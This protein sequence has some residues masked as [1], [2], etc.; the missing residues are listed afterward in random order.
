MKRKTEIC[1]LE[2]VIN[3]TKK[4]CETQPF[5]K[6]YMFFMN[7]N[8]EKRKEKPEHYHTTVD[9]NNKTS[10]DHHFKGATELGHSHQT[11]SNKGKQIVG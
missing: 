6:I 3:E 8:K 9:P 7:E 10:K 1:Y 2:K 5:K 4:S 11:P